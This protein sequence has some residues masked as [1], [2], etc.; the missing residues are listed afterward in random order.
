MKENN[1][2]FMKG[3]LIGALSMLLF[4]GMVIAILVRLLW[5]GTDVLSDET[6]A[7][8]ELVQYYIESQ[9]LYEIDQEALEDGIL[10]GY[11]DGLDDP[12]TVYYNEEETQDILESAS[13]EYS[14]I[15][16]VMMQDV[17]TGIITILSVYEDCPAAI[18]GLQD[19]D[20]LDQVNGES[21]DGQDVTS[22]V[23]KIKGEEGTTVDITVLRGSEY[24]SI[25]YTVTRASIE[26]PSVTYEMLEDQVGYIYVSE[27]STSTL[28]QFEDAKTD[29][30]SQGME[31]LIIDLR[32]NPG[33]NLDTVCSML[34]LLLPEGVIVST[35]DKDGEGETYYSSG[36]NEF[37]LPLVVLVN[38][39]SASASEIFAAAIQDY[40][41]GEIVG[42]TTYGKGVVQSLISLGDG[43]MIKFTSSEYFTPLGNSIHGIGVIPD[44]EVDYDYEDLETDEQL[45]KAIEVIM[46]LE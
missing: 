2:G 20:I 9:Y 12:Y 32:S 43:T 7:K 33:G 41:I 26:Y 39:Y 22:V 36:E 10:Y 44:V 28:E 24:E 5:S 35:Q 13:G 38:E 16:A 46:E 19:G 27:F 4:S 18:A 23:T 15:G 8:L 40:G 25:T 30:E 11:M 34:E 31:R 6:I 21:V 3:A 1:K 37:T 42:M 17:E 29:L 45:E 14:G